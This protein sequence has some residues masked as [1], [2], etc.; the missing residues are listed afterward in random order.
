MSRD[1]KVYIV[2]DEIHGQELLQRM[3]SEC[4]P[5]A[6][7]VGIADNLAKAARDFQDLDID[8]AFLDVQ[9]KGQNIFQLLDKIEILPF[10]VVFTTA[11]SDYAI[12]A[13]Q[14]SALDYLVK[15]FTTE[16]LS[17]AISRAIAAQDS[18]ERIQALSK[19]I[20]KPEKLGIAVIN[21]FRFVDLKNI[22]FLHAD[23]T[24][25]DVYTTDGNKI[26]S[27]RTLS[28]YADVLAEENFYRIH[29]SYIVNCGQVASV[30]SKDLSLFLNSGKELPISVRK[31]TGFL[32]KLEEV[33]Y[34]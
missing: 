7:I 34:M 32:Q 28:Y 25:T 29:H 13:I 5:Q 4:C 20:H 16:K 17:G 26:T 8:L 2:E 33:N 18:K 15:P 27:S 22:L 11:Y 19:N 12:N 6:Q 14:L 23:R 10:N 30:N 1:L 3:I 21:G 24:Y 31:K 9:V